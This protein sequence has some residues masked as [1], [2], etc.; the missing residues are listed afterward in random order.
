MRIDALLLVVN[1]LVVELI[2]T[3]VA[4]AVNDFVGINKDANMDN[5]SFLIVKES[6]IARLSMVNKLNRLSGLNLL[7]CIAG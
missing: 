2:D 5:S 4:G 1:A 7:P 3:N 6:N